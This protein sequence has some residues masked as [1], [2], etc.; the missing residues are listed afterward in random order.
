MS[1]TDQKP[2][3]HVSTQERSNE[4][5]ESDNDSNNGMV[6]AMKNDGNGNSTPDNNNSSSNQQPSNQ[7][8]ETSQ[9]NTNFIFDQQ[10]EALT[11]SANKLMIQDIVVDHLFPRIKFLDYN[12][13]LEF[14]M[15][16]GTICQY[17]FVSPNFIV[18]KIR[19]NLFG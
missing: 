1:Q 5:N 10:N 13:D 7:E 12:N 19:G 9:E 15:E 16:E 11:N 18:L 17:L 14:S 2:S 3:A 4:S 6:L 8:H